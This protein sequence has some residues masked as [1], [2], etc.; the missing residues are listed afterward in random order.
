L[1]DYLATSELLVALD[2]PCTL[3]QAAE[4]DHRLE[5]RVHD[6]LSATGSFALPHLVARIRALEAAASAPSLRLEAGIRL[7]ASAGDCVSIMAGMGSAAVA[8]LAELARAR[9]PRHYA[10]RTYSA[11]ACVAGAGAV[12]TLEALLDSED[13]NEV[14]SALGKTR[15]TDAAEVLLERLAPGAPSDGAEFRLTRAIVARALVELGAPLGRFL[16]DPDEEVR[17]WAGV[18]EIGTEPNSDDERA[19]Q[20]TLLRRTCALVP[21]YAAY[22]Q[23][24]DLVF[25][26]QVHVDPTAIVACL[27]DANAAPGKE[28]AALRVRLIKALGDPPSVLAVP[29]LCVAAADPDPGQVDYGIALRESVSRAARKALAKIDTPLAQSFAV[30]PEP[31]TLLKLMRQLPD[32]FERRLDEAAARL[33][34]TPRREKRRATPA[35]I[36]GFLWASLAVAVSAIPLWWPSA[37]IAAVL[38]WPAWSSRRGG[39]LVVV[40]A[41][42]PSPDFSVS[43]AVLAERLAGRARALIVTSQRFVFGGDRGLALWVWGAALSAAAAGALSFGRMGFMALIAGYLFVGS[44]LLVGALV[45]GSWSSSACFFA[46]CLVGRLLGSTS[47]WFA[48]LWTAAAFLVAMLGASRLPP[49]GQPRRVRF[50]ARAED[51]DDLCRELDGTS[52][53]T[54]WLVPVPTD[55]VVVQSVAWAADALQ[56]VLLASAGAAVIDASSAT[57]RQVVELHNRCAD[58]EVPLLILIPSEQR[59]L[60]DILLELELP[61]ETMRIYYRQTVTTLELKTVPGS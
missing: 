55:C 19:R 16:E 15:S 17:F 31:A 20:A 12:P 40:F 60:V 25:V 61:K 28:R 1:R 10:Y 41:P 53:R 27:R 37:A 49:I 38:L 52:H 9:A 11:L 50:V 57:P 7:L 14:A 8:P 42:N 32:D 33:S 51:L 22:E 21:K 6:A 45:G 39:E 43:G 2:D 58:L 26:G 34:A 5:S 30:H 46:A 36:A 54:R 35:W 29:E 18:R 24:L 4:L 47:G 13:G 59:G 56:R 44:Y 23:L 48:L 3:L